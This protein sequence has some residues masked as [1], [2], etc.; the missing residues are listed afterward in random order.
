MSSCAIPT[1]AQSRTGFQ[2]GP[3]NSQTKEIRVLTLQPGRFGEPI[4]S[5]LDVVSLK[6]KPKFEALSY[7][8]GD[9][10]VTRNISVNSCLRPVTKNLEAA[11]QRLRYEASP[12]RIWADAVCINQEDGVE[13]C[14]QVG[15]MEDIYK[16]ATETTLFIGDYIDDPDFPPY[17]PFDPNIPPGSYA[18]VQSTFALIKKLAQDHHIFYQEGDDG[19]EPTMP[20]HSI[21]LHYGCTEGILS[22]VSQPWWSRIWTVQETILPGSPAVQYGAIRVNW[23]VFTAAADNLAKHLFDKCCHASVGHG[24]HSPYPP[25]VT[26]YNK[27][28]ALVRRRR[29]PLPLDKLLRKFRDRTASDPRD[30]IYGL[31]GLAHDDA[32]AAG[33]QLDY[34]LGVPEVYSSVVRKLIQL[35]GDLCPLGRHP[36]QAA[37][38]HGLP[39]WVPDYSVTSEWTHYLEPSMLSELWA[40]CDLRRV[41]IQQQ[42]NP[43][44][45]EV[46]GVVFDEVVAIGD[47]VYPSPRAEIGATIG[48]WSAMLQSL[49]N[50]QESYPAGDH[51]GTYEELW[52]MLICRGVLWRSESDTYRIAT[53]RD[54]DLVEQ[55]IPNIRAQRPANID[56]QLLYWQRLFVTH[57]GYIGLA[58]P[59]VTVG[60]T[61]HVLVGGRTPLILR[62]AL[63]SKGSENQLNRFI[64]VCDA[65][66]LGIM[67]GGILPS[68][69]EPEKLQSFLLV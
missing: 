39:S 62:K 54:R 44:V 48:T 21:K 1:A 11:L 22:L 40:P 67:N 25:L 36:S 50:W 15:L 28:W 68:D 19:K 4:V 6:D 5:T 30:M 43:L 58:S 13:K 69:G 16:S 47:V 45:L 2:Y 60:D 17:S 59:N 37:D 57:R 33:I 14:H 27:V 56:L 20:P 55:E 35:R 7:T 3:I 42:T 9:R 46:F 49:G 63:L 23:D 53:M 12:R 26:F 41:P 31:L 10:T 18:G 38:L 66:V 32:A 61:V 29:T 65:F 8:W 51:E 34:M 52:W 24:S 64:Y